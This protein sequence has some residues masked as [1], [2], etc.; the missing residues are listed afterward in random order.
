MTDDLQALVLQNSSELAL[1]QAAQ[2]AGIRSLRTLGL[3]WVQRGQT[4]LGEVL[5]NTPD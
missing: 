1:R 2:A 5:L 3:V 4:T